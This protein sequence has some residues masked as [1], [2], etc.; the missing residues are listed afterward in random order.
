MTIE[1]V[2]RGEELERQLLRI[3]LLGV[4]AALLGQLLTDIFPQV[5][6]LERVAARHI[7]DDRPRAAA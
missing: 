1:G 4:G 2:D 6:E 5:A 3:E 7:V